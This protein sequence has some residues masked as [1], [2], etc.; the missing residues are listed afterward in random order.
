M[1]KGDYN[2]KVLLFRARKDQMKS[3]LENLYVNKYY[4]LYPKVQRDGPKK[5]IFCNF[6][7][8]IKQLRREKN[9][10]L[11]FLSSELG[12][13]ISEQH[14]GA[15]VMK[16]KFDQKGIEKVITKYIME[17]VVCRS[18]LGLETE[19]K[20]DNGTRLTFLICENCKASITVHSITKGYIAQKRKKNKKFT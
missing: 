14:D 18:C 9:H 16:G 12:S 20:K 10:V 19:I 7:E 8:V 5:T 15:L 4:N 13:F 1:K 3:G 2:Y 17:Y 6:Q 11:S